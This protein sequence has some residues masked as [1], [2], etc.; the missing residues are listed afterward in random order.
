[1][2]TDSKLELVYGYD[3]EIA[4]WVAERLKYCT[5]QDMVYHR[6]IGVIKNGLVIAG[7]VYHNYRPEFKSIEVSIAID[8]KSWANRRIVS[9]LFRYPF[10]QLECQ[11]MT[12]FIARKN[13]KSRKLAKQFGFKEEGI[14]R[15]AV[16]DD[17]LV[18]LG[19]MRED[20]ERWFK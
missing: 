1:M 20:A 18:V 5:P 6:S 16:G 7:V 11:R 2:V 13:K 14:M 15:K 4:S 12:A 8:D 17:D 3:S 10:I 9:A 19:M